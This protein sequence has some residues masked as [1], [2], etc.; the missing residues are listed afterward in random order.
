MVARTFSLDAGGVPRLLKRWAL[1]DFGGVTRLAKRV[2]VRDPSGVPRLVF[3]AGLNGMLVAGSYIDP[4]FWSGIG[5]NNYFGFTSLP[6]YGSF[7]LSSG[8]LTVEFIAALTEQ[9]VPTTFV[10]FAVVYSSPLQS[11]S[12]PGPS[13]FTSI[14]INGQVF[15]SASATSTTSSASGF[16]GRQWQ[17]NARS[18]GMVPG[19]TYV[20][21]FA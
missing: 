20:V 21:S 15:T 11:G 9:T 6:S 16:L 14:T 18:I 8:Q 13:W 1:R 19:N 7:T 10:T 12:D 2:F 17:W 4:P 5:Y 3:W